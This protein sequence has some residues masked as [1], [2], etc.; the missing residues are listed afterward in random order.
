M[1]KLPRHAADLRR[2]LATPSRPSRRGDPNGL[3]CT[4]RLLA[5][6]ALAASLTSAGWLLAA[7]AAGPIANAA[8]IHA[9]YNTRG[10]T[11]RTFGAVR[12][13][14][15]GKSCAKREVAVDWNRRGPAGQ[16]GATGVT[17]ATGATG[18]AGA[19]GATGANGGNGANGATGAMGSAGAAGTQGAT[20]TA[21]VTGAT[22]QT[23]A[24]GANG[25]NG[26]TGATGVTGATGTT[27]AT[28]AAGPTG[29]TGAAGLAFQGI[30][31]SSKIYSTDDAVEYNGSSWI[32]LTGNF[33][34]VPG[35]DGTVWALLAQEGSTGASGATGTTGAAGA[36]GATGPTGA[37][38]GTGAAGSTGASG[39]TGATGA[40]GVSAPND[41]FYGPGV[42]GNT[43]FGGPVY[44][45]E[46]GH[47]IIN[48]GGFSVSGNT[49][50]VVPATGL[51]D[52][53]LRVVT[54]AP[55]NRTEGTVE[56]DVNSSLLDSTEG[57]VTNKSQLSYTIQRLV[58]ITA[59]ESIEAKIEIGP[60]SEFP[61]EASGTEI[62][63]YRVA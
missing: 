27:G 34:V 16:R 43:L 40:T 45:Y 35:S 60:G 4:A 19:K 56:L 2:M 51:Y 55:P 21:G 3:Q 15:P 54:T 11:Y 61:V 22:G 44:F 12:P 30:W 1:L 6:I 53:S 26:A 62:S 24:S 9:C 49:K 37:T 59:L 58:Q 42:A 63:I 38:G 17:G 36:T 7:G 13:I 14:R 18:T 52:V 41:S 39:Q 50:I 46:S 10:G 8:M 23:G 47:G 31:S 20:G 33:N 48:D 32:A 57:V 28:G 25:T 5:R 29:A